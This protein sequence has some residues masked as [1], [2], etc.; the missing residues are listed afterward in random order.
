MKTTKVV[1]LIVTGFVWIMVMVH[2]K[3]F[4]NARKNSRQP[5]NSLP[6]AIT[7]N[8]DHL[9]NVVCQ[10]SLQFP[11]ALKSNMNPNYQWHWKNPFRKSSRFLPAPSHFNCLISPTHQSIYLHQANPRIYNKYPI[12]NQET[13]VWYVAPPPTHFPKSFL[14]I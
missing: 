1:A 5:S 3:N 14:R 6:Y 9:K 10:T 8:I 11:P 7:M 13:L 4:N 2:S 12:A